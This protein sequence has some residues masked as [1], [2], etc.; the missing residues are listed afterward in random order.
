MTIVRGP[1]SEGR[2]QGAS[3]GMTITPEGPIRPTLH[4]LIDGLAILAIHLMDRGKVSRIGGSC[5]LIAGIG[6]TN[7]V[8]SLE[9]GIESIGDP[10]RGQGIKRERCIT[11]SQPLVA[12]RSIKLRTAGIHP[13]TGALRLPAGLGTQGK[14]LGRPFQASL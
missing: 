4:Q 8:G 3:V 1:G 9:T 13:I 7:G 10:L 2:H 11:D 14:Q 6:L 5:P 12:G